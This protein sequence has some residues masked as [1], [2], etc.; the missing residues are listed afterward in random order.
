MGGTSTDVTS[1]TP[2]GCARRAGPRGKVRDL[3]END[4]ML[5]PP[6]AELR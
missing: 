6:A 1:D 2:F 3:L 4:A 5:A